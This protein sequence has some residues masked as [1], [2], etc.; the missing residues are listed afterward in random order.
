MRLADLRTLQGLSEFITQR[1]MHP[2]VVRK[3]LTMAQRGTVPSL[4][5]A[6]NLDE[7]ALLAAAVRTYFPDG[8]WRQR[9]AAFVQLDGAGRDR[10]LSLSRLNALITPERFFDIIIEAFPGYNFTEHPETMA[11][12][13]K[14]L[15]FSN[16]TEW[17][18]NGEGLLGVNQII[19]HL[20]EELGEGA[21]DTLVEIFKA[22]YPNLPMSAAG[23]EVRSTE[24]AVQVSLEIQ[25]AQVALALY[26]G[27]RL[28]SLEGVEPA[29]LTRFSRRVSGERKPRGADEPSIALPVDLGVQ[30]EAAERRRA[31]PVL[32]AIRGRIDGGVFDSRES[33][34]AD[35]PN[36]FTARAFEIVAGDLAA[37]G[38]TAE[39]VDRGGYGA[40]D[41]IEVKE[42]T[43]LIAQRNERQ[44][45]SLVNLV[46]T[47]VVG[48]ATR[49]ELPSRTTEV[50]VDIALA[51]L[52]IAPAL[53]RF[54]FSKGDTGGYG[55][56]KDTIEIKRPAVKKAPPPK[57]DIEKL[58]AV[59]DAS[60]IRDLEDLMIERKL[61]GLATSAGQASAAQQRVVAVL[62][63]I[64]EKAELFSDSKFERY[65]RQ[66]KM[67]MEDPT[68]GVKLFRAYAID[69]PELL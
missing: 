3:A 8:V 13:E 61:L 32:V 46:S 33:F 5:Q 19:H 44:A 34:D 2:R 62:D 39:L 48:S 59:L 69:L 64:L 54:K 35:Q 12:I 11:K 53:S 4:K 15:W 41:K 6:G 14:R 68:P 60:N 26:E 16:I 66:L 58:V 67:N 47:A 50:A 51:A 65:V 27:A 38:Y 40:S 36:G 31:E 21:R 37:E 55:G 56:S 25:A 1:S 29:V 7:T 22:K 63:Q 17:I 28:D 43:D 10:D 24:S 18:R 52:N 45:Q 57:G 20:M 42:G 9:V 23:L 30:L 49:V